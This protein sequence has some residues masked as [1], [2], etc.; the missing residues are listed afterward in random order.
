[1]NE[2]PLFF[3]LKALGRLIIEYQLESCFGLRGAAAEE[4]NMATTGTTDIVEEKASSKR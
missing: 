2:G 1:M 4:E 3:L